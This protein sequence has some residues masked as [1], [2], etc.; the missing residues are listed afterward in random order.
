MLFANDPNL[1]FVLLAGSVASID[2]A[3][4]VQL[5]TELGEAYKRSR[6]IRDISRRAQLPDRHVG[7]PPRARMVVDI[8]RA[9][10][11]LAD[12][13]SEQRPTLTLQSDG[14]HF[15]WFTEFSDIS[16]RRRDKASARSA[17][18]QEEELQ[19][20]R[21]AADAS[22]DYA[23]H[24]SM[25]KPQ[26]RRYPTVAPAL[27]HDDLSLRMRM[28][29]STALEP[30]YM[31]LM[32][33][34]ADNGDQKQYHLA[35]IGR[36]H[37]T[38]T[39][40]VLG[41]VVIAPDGSEQ[42]YL[43]SESLLCSLDLGVDSG[44]KVNLWETAVVDALVAMGH[45]HRGSDDAIENVGEIKQSI[46]NR[47][48]SG[49]SGRLSLGLISIFVGE[50]DPNKDCKLTLTKG[51]W[52]Q[53]NASLEYAYINNATQALPWRHTLSA[54]ARVKLR[55]PEDITTQALAH[56]TTLSG[57]GG[58]AALFSVTCNDCFVKPIF[59]GESFVAA[60]GTSMSHE[61]VQPP[62]AR[63][64]EPYVGWDFRQRESDAIGP[65]K[66]ANQ[67]LPLE[68]DKSDQ[69]QRPMIRL[70]R[71]RFNWLVK[72]ELATN[73]I[74]VKLTGRFGHIWI[75]ADISH[76]YS[77]LLALDPIRKIA[78]AWR[79]TKSA[80]RPRSKLDFSTEIT[81]PGL[82][83]HLEFPLHEQ[84]YVHLATSTIAHRTGT[85]MLVGSDAA[86]VYVPSIRE[87]G[88][89]E[90]LARFKRF[91]A[92]T[93]PPDIDLA[94]HVTSEAVRVRIPQ[95]YQL[96]KLILNIT[97][98]L[99][100]VK[101][102]VAN[103]DTGSFAKVKIPG[104]EGPKKIP[105]ITFDI[106]HISLQA[107]DDPI[108]TKLNL[109]WRVGMHEQQAR[110]VLQEMYDRKLQ[111][112]AEV[113]EPGL[114]T[115]HASSDG[116]HSQPHASKLTNKR[117]TTLEDAQSRL[118]HHNA[119][120]YVRRFRAAREEQ[121]RR[122]VRANRYMQNLGVDIK[123]PI[124]IVAS[125]SS[126]PLFRARL[127][128]FRLS[129]GDLGISRSEV[130][131]YMGD[132]SSSPFDDDVE[133]TLMVP[134]KLQMTL[135][136]ASFRLRDYPLPLVRIQ[137]TQD[138]TPA[139]HLGTP[140]IIAEEIAGDESLVMIPSE[141]IPADCGRKGA[142]HFTVDIAKTLMPV[143]T[144]ARPKITISTEKTTEFTWGNSYQ[145]AI[146]DFMKV[147]E[148]FSHPPRDLSPRVGFWDKFR[149]ILH[150]QVTMELAGACH[151]HLKGESQSPCL[152]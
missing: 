66:F 111:L 43:D 39:G 86:L 46:L 61:R 149:L 121:R 17:F 32:L 131:N 55:L 78:G 148:T 37:G 41:T 33:G 82:T 145:P 18:K 101:L 38:L 15:G 114:G 35:T 147:V 94:V 87:V 141:I 45:A 73:G 129:V 152:I 1:A 2:A 50:E 71:L 14:L 119:R 142:S 110:M 13:V 140:F 60:G 133:F 98:F 27:L 138:G 107:Q 72:R 28:D 52:L 88:K 136:E 77:A 125:T 80:S 20:R 97:V 115:M 75:I 128:G 84:L 74:E 19:D 89:W 6:P 102:L 56:Y 49:I 24:D 25:L 109:I 64:E 47:L 67:R 96:S 12:R 69:A 9:S 5:L 118:D 150:W 63:P 146:Q 99:K 40:D 10:I 70:N 4:D 30:I 79:R 34:N 22:T 116:K 91:Y 139:F 106:D 124:E 85:G 132:V 51:L 26:L 53:T 8:G 48:P 103:I 42:A 137:P 16:A 134:L 112:L 122:E 151:L 65:S 23:Q 83:A 113:E 143:K 76:A 57:H 93:S 117:T 123:L 95:A 68:I 105:Q 92:K 21:S 104:P 130:I 58:Q 100:S 29:A 126:P 81:I 59:D 36:M 108:E 127:T 44:V 7:L 11:L 135:K 31:N 3:G 144:Y 62:Q 90:E 120:V 54:P